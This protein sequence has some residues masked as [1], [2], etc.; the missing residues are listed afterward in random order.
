[1]PESQRGP[2]KEIADRLRDLI[3]SRGYALKDLE[4]KMG[5]GRGYVAE[6]LRGSKRLTVELVVEIAAALDADPQQIFSP[7]RR[8]RT[9]PSE[10][11]EE[12]AGDAELPASMQDASEVLQ[13][14]LLT[15]AEQGVVSVAEVEATLR[16]LR[17]RGSAA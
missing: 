5:R 2:R 7:P 15:L 9:W 3:E 11:A 12:G 1:M 8:R 10:I 4:E 14:L 17:A 6:A 13:A 16:R